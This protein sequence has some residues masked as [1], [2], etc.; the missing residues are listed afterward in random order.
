MW[1]VLDKHVG[2]IRTSLVEIIKFR[3]SDLVGVGLRDNLPILFP[4]AKL[5]TIEQTWPH[6]PSVKFVFPDIA[7]TVMNSQTAFKNVGDVKKFTDTVA[8]WPWGDRAT[9]TDDKP[10]VHHKLLSFYR[11]WKVKID[12]RCALIVKDPKSLSI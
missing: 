8:K 3:Q 6:D 9:L 1:G 4:G 12:N 7:K 10:A 11:H 2:A 5:E